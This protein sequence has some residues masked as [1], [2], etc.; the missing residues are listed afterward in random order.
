MI[1]KTIE[2]VLFHEIEKM[3]NKEYEHIGF[4]DNENKFGDIIGSFV[5][6]VGMK[7]RAKLT[8]QVYDENEESDSKNR[9]DHR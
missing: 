1:K 7:K 9:Q 2:G 6:K 4:R 3:G 8:I 5:P